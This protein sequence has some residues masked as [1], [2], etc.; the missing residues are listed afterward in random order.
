V[1]GQGGN[2]DLTYPG[3]NGDPLG[4]SIMGF[5]RGLPSLV[6]FGMGSFTPAANTLA[7]LSFSTD[8][9][10]IPMQPGTYTNAQRD[11]SSPGPPGL[12]VS[13]QNRGCNTISGSFVVTDF[14]FVG[15]PLNETITSFSASFEQHCEGET[16]ALF[17]TFTYNANG[18]TPVPEPVG[19]ALVGIGVLGLI[20]RRLRRHVPAAR[21][22]RPPDPSFRRNR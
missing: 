11:S 21:L 8:A 14:S 7:F 15:P 6:D 10:G 18:A 9:L 4:A 17:G 19:Y 2:Y 13:F 1:I 16:P 20:F 12:Q 22:Y 3:T 5:L